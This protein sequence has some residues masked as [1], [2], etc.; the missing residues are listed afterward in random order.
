VDFRRPG[1]VVEIDGNG[2]PR[3]PRSWV[4]AI[5]RPEALWRA[6]GYRDDTSIGRWVR[7]L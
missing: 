6:A 1:L 2:H 3:S 5:G 7:S 4:A